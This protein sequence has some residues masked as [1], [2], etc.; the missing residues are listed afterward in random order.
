[1][2]SCAID[3]KENR[4]VIVSNI[5]GAFLRADMDDNIHMLLEV[6]VAE[7]I[8]KLD[9]TIYRKHLWYNKHAKPMLYVQL[10][11]ALYETLQAVLLFWKLL[12][13]TLEEW[14]FALN[15][16]NKCLASKDIEGKQCTI[17]WHV[18]NLKILHVSK[19]VL[20]DILNKVNNKFR[21]ESPLMT[22]RRKVLEYLGM[23]IDYQQQGKVKFIMYDYIEKLLEELP[24]DIELFIQY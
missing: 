5:P 12:L 9:P 11:K 14:G 3:A 6:T 10:K 17:I 8:I 21:K 13:E 1:M 24:A 19:D 7:M 20:E 18:D 23:K 4:Y 22:C 15:P 16:Y 2:L